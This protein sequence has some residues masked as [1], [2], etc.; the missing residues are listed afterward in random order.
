MNIET[1][2][3]TDLK[4]SIGDQEVIIPIKPPRQYYRRNSP[5]ELLSVYFVKL[6]GILPQIA[7]ILR[8]KK[9]KN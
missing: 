1:K 7:L 2:I 8:W 4:N 9:R 3:N 6:T 5:Q